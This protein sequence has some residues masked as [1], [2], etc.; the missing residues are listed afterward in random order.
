MLFSKKNN[1]DYIL[2][3]LSKSSTF[4]QEL[5]IINRLVVGPKFFVEFDR[6]EDVE[7]FTEKIPYLNRAATVTYARPWSSGY[8]LFT[9]GKISEAEARAV[10]AAIRS[11]GSGQTGATFTDWTPPVEQ[12][13]K[14]SLHGGK[15]GV[16]HQDSV[17]RRLSVLTAEVSGIG[18]GPGEI[19]SDT[20][21][22]EDLGLDSLDCVELIMLIEEEFGVELPDEDAAMLRTMGAAVAY[23]ARAQ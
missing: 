3:Q 11:P 15:P 10:F 9:G 5:A 18:H 19:T 12:V 13:A 21:F 16:A 22:I 14:V 6:Y 2:A 7:R 1:S 17:F 8:H 20:R 4:E 23:I